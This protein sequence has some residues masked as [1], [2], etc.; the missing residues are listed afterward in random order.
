[1]GE[2]EQKRGRKRLSSTAIH[3]GQKRERKIVRDPT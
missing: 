3:F 1:M 2:D